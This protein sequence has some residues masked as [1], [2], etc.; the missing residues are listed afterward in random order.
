MVFTVGVCHISQAGPVVFFLHDF[1]VLSRS[2]WSEQLGVCRS[3]IWSLSLYTSVLF[4]T[5]YILSMTFRVENYHVLYD[6][7][8]YY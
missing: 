2:S 8:C 6:Y 4:T 1:F 7:T 3:G 5:E